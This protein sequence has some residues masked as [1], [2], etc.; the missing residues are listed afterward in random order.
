M[1]EDGYKVKEPEIS[2]LAMSEDGYKVIT[3]QA[4]DTLP[5]CSARCS[6]PNLDLTNLDS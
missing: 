4:W 5:K 1:S 3:L 6:K 2:T